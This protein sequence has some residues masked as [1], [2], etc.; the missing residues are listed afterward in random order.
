MRRFLILFVAACGESSGT[1]VDASPGIDSNLLIDPLD[2]IGAVEEVQSGYMFTEGPQWR[3]AEGVLL[4]TDKGASLQNAERLADRLVHRD[5]EG[6][7]RRLCLECV[8]LYGASRWRCGHAQQGAMA[9]A[10]L[11]AELVQVLQRC[12]GFHA[13]FHPR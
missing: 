11:P 3:E 6:D 8:H 7:H 1:S 12:E 5:R 10:E 4:F 9:N 13:A 2:G